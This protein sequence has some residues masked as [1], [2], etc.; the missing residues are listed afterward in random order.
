MHRGITLELITPFNDDQPVFVSGNFCDWYP[1][2][3]A[4]QMKKVEAGRYEFQ[5][6]ENLDYSKKL[7]YKYTR[8]AWNCVEL[9]GFGNPPM[10]RV[11]K[12]DASNLQDYVPF[13]RKNGK[14]YDEELMPILETIQNFEM[15]QLKKKRNVHVLLPADYFLTDKQYPV[16]Y[17]QDAQNL[18]G[19]GSA[20]GNW[21]I[22]EKL[23]ILKA[24]GKGD[25]IVVAID[26]GQED[27][28]E[29][30][31]P[32]KSRNGLGKGKK[33]AHFV[34]K[35][36]K[37]FIDKQYRT[38][39][40]R[41]NTGIGGS[42]MGGLVSIYAGLMYPDLI[43]KMMIFSPSLWVSPKIYFDAIEFFQPINTKIYVYA[44]GQESQFM[45]ENVERFKH[46]LDKQGFKES[47][48]SIKLSVDQSGKHNEAAWSNEFTAATEWLFE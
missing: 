8:G 28:F 6:P 30:Y 42:S 20:Y 17:L 21:K 39:P 5:F 24:R 23:S 12:K 36:L 46:T 41:E 27:R 38:R 18:F 22:D 1:N 40:E 11:L 10:N 4:F 31:S 29:E 14:N 47:Q 43:A 37:P 34:A 7:E 13:W 44:G 45:L 25:L 35:T 26:H 32:Y 2:K 9:D 15:P 16:L 48:L 3:T 33:Y 19:E